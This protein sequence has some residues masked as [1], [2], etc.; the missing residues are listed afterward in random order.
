[1]PKRRRARRRWRPL[2][3]SASTRSSSARA[4]PTVPSKRPASTSSRKVRTASVKPSGLSPGTLWPAPDTVARRARRISTTAR[5]ATSSLR[6]SLSAPRT[7]S[8]G[9]DSS[10][11][12][13]QSSSPPAA[14][15]VRTAPSPSRKRLSN[16]HVHLPF[17]SGRRRWR[18]RSR[19]F[20]S[21]R[22]GLKRMALRTNSSNS[23]SSGP[24][25]KRMMFSTPSRA[26]SGPTSTSTRALT[27]S[28]WRVAYSTA[29]R[30][31]MLWP[32][33]TKRSSP[34]A[35]RTASTSA[36]KASRV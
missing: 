23:S 34:S 16:F 3:A 30:P 19:M 20:S 21:P 33:R 32:M 14:P 28:G 5:H 35:S 17:S 9:G 4:S 13:R 2:A 12:S 7:S 8:T 25:V 11:K 18:M 24:R 31:P 27:R 15:P 36:T 1:M 29:L 10:R 6:M 22:R 26:A